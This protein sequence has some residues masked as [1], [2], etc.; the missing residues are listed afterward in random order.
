MS[1]KGKVFWIRAK[2]LNAWVPTFLEDNQDDSLS[3]DES[4]E[5]VVEDIDGDKENKELSD[6]DRVSKS[7]FS[8]ANDLIHE[9]S[10]SN[11]TCDV[12]SHSEDPFNTYGILISPY[13]DHIITAGHVRVLHVPSRFQFI[14]IFTKR[15]PSALFEDFRSSLS[16]RPPL[17]QTARAYWSI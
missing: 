10:Y 12:G 15:L 8:H 5:N 11:K 14:D 7:S 3:N 9:N 1:A 17:A 6:G 13:D 2:E 16:V 4:K